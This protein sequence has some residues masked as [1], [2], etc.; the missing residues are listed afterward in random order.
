MNVRRAWLAPARPAIVSASVLLFA[1]SCAPPAGPSSPS[2]NGQEATPPNTSSH[3][4]SPPAATTSAPPPAPAT[5]SDVLQSGRAPLDACYERARVADPQLGRTWVEITFDIDATGT[6][7]TVDLHYRNRMA[8]AA[9]ECMREAALALRFPS[10]MAG[11][12]MAKISFM[13]A[14]PAAR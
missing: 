8:E 11:K 2:A 3:D 14:P 4:A 10:S 13:P 9:K 6:P 12:Q 5:P 7:R 1:S